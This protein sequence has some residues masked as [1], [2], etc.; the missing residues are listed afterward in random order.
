MQNKCVCIADSCVA[1][2]LYI[3]TEDVVAAARRKKRKVHADFAA[4]AADIEAIKKSLTIEQDKV[5]IARDKHAAMVL[6]HRRAEEHFTKSVEIEKS[7]SNQLAEIL[8]ENSNSQSIQ[9][10]RSLAKVSWTIRNSAT[11]ELDR[12]T[13]KMKF[14]KANLRAARAR[15][16][17]MVNKYEELITRRDKASETLKR[18]DALMSAVTEFMQNEKGGP[19]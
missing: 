9:D 18:E 8:S 15:V 12:L 19:N 1:K 2:G 11:A 5:I 10:L 3:I 17:E 14:V 6:H 16:E 7:T 4:T 13:R